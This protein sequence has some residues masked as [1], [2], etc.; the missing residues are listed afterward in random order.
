MEWSP[1]TS[2]PLP[3]LQLLPFRYVAELSYCTLCDPLIS[4]SAGLSVNRTSVVVI[5]DSGLLIYR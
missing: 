2:L 3:L 5:L 1:K 4:R